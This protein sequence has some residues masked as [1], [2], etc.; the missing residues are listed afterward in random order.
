M[1][2]ASNALRKTSVD[3]SAQLKKFQPML[4]KHS[5]EKTTQAVRRMN[6]ASFFRV[7]ELMRAE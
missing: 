3:S 7:I 2:F 4:D 1:R 6:R 5:C